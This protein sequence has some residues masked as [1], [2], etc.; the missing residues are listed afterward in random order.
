MINYLILSASNI[1]KI[2]ALQVLFRA[3]PGEI[4]AYRMTMCSSCQVGWM[5]I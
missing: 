2:S 1:G 3:A 4:V 5:P